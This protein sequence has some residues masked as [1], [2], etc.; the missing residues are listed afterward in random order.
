MDI[1]YRPLLLLPL[2]AAALSY[3]QPAVEPVGKPYALPIEG[4][5]VAPRFSPGGDQLALSTPQYRGI[6]LY[7]FASGTLRELTA[8]PAAGFGLAWSPDGNWIAA[9]P[10]KF[11]N[12]RRYN[13]LVI[14][15]VNTGE[16]RQLTPFQ[17]TLPGI[18]NWTSDGNFIFLDRTSNFQ[19]Y[20]I[21][22][23][24]KPD[25]GVTLLFARGKRIYQRD[26]LGRE[27]QPLLTVAGEILN[28]VP[29]PQRTRVAYE[30]LGGHLWILD[31][32]TNKTYDLGPGNEPVWH[33]EGD[34]L[35]FMTTRDD[36][37]QITEADIYVV[38]SDGSGR[39]KLTDTPTVLEMRPTWSPNGKMIV[40]DTDG[41]GPI[42]VQEIR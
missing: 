22:P 33:P 5:Y 38:N 1:H 21:D 9:R 41:W 15:Q 34:K 18:P 12:R 13:T 7:S 26:L 23:T 35:A 17:T 27:E 10:A 11:E 14:I 20:A 40:Y 28:M 31:L 36:G 37:H 6:Y 39:M 4:V 25:T 32:N 2:L 16:Q 24:V 3:G 8:E 30:I 29:N 19:L 42:M